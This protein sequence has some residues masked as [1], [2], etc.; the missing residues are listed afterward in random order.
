M[1]IMRAARK[2]L[3][4]STVILVCSFGVRADGRADDVLMWI[5][6]HLQ[7]VSYTVT[8]PL[9]TYQ[10]NESAKMEFDGCYA[11]ILEVVKTPKSNIQTALSFD[12]S[13]IQQE[14]IRFRSV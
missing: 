7:T 12:L 4:L 10:E 1:D 11:T 13:N 6:N 14:R 8:T 5:S 3:A 2:I 9:A